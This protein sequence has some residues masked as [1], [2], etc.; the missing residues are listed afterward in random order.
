MEASYIGSEAGIDLPAAALTF[1]DA[2]AVLRGLQAL[3]PSAEPLQPVLYYLIAWI[4]P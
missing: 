1:F 2:V 4:E 3:R